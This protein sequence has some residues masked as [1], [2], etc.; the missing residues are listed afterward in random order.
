[1][2][3]KKNRL[4]VQ[5]VVNKKGRIYRG[6]LLTIKVFS[7]TLPLS[8]FGVV[9]S[10]NLIKKATERNRVKR[11][12]FESARIVLNKWPTADYLVIVSNPKIL[13]LNQNKINEEFILPSFR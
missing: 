9:I 7:T 5:S 11:I 10:K 3:P 12:I 4:P 8:R 13:E 6:A 1:M 2:L